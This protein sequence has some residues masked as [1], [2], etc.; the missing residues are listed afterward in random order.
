MFTGSVNSA[1]LDHFA[2]TPSGKRTAADSPCRSAHTNADNVGFGGRLM[3]SSAGGSSG[4]RRTP[5]G[6]KEPV[7]MS[8]VVLCFIHQSSQ[9]ACSSSSGQAM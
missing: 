3:S 7:K 2:T 1:L 9:S 4:G 8:S 5:V 6:F